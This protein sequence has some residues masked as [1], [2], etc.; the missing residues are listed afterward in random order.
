MP[1][2]HVESHTVNLLYLVFGRLAFPY[3]VTRYVQHIYIY[4]ILASLQF[5]VLVKN[6]KFSKH[7]GTLNIWDLQ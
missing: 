4:N 3:N 6:A 5:S 1:T 7:K 2:H